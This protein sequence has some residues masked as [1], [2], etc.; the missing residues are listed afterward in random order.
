MRTG[1]RPQAEP[2]TRLPP[3]LATTTNVRHDL[4][5]CQV[6]EAGK[7]TLRAP[8][9]PRRW[10][11]RKTPAAATAISERNRAAAPVRPALARRD[12][13]CLHG[14]LPACRVVEQVQGP[15]E[16]LDAIQ[17]AVRVEN[18]LVA[19]DIADPLD[20]EQQVTSLGE[21]GLVPLELSD[22][23]GGLRYRS[24]SSAVRT[25]DMSASRHAGATTEHRPQCAAVLPRLEA[26]IQQWA[27][28]PDAPPQAFVEQLRQLVV[29]LRLCVGKDVAL[30]FG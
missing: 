16:D 30:L 20:R 23:G 13:R 5:E 4:I 11:R 14:D 2:E 17:H 15:V 7:P 22:A 9:V 3:R 8:S 28:E 26:I 19:S 25:T 18:A 27:T 1:G 6:G 12:L 24:G 29:V 10:P 21:V